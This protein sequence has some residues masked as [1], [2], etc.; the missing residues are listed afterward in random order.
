MCACRSF[1]LRQAQHDRSLMHPHGFKY[2]EQSHL[3]R[4]YADLT[5]PS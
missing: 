1:R 3:S 4:Y 5:P 2:A